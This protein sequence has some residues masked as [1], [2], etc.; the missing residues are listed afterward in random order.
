V[1]ADRLR[2]LKE[3]ILQIIKKII[4][5]I[6]LIPSF[7]LIHFLLSMFMNNLIFGFYEN[8]KNDSNYLEIVKDEYKGKMY[9]RKA[10][11]SSFLGNI[12]FYRFEDS[13]EIGFYEINQYL[14]VDLE[15]I[16]IF[17]SIMNDRKD[18]YL[19]L[20]VGRNMPEF[21]Y[22]IY[23]TFDKYKNINIFS[24]YDISETKLINTKNLFYLCT[25]NYGFSFSSNKKFYDFHLKTLRTDLE[26][27]ELVFF[28]YNGKT[29]FV[30]KYINSEL[31][32]GNTLN[33]KAINYVLLKDIIKK[34]YFKEQD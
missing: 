31:E 26:P 3:K 22:F 24:K 9:L 28:K 4:V 29:I 33:A 12:N 17:N 34:K 6:L 8:K 25:F 30:T 19:E 16:K 1:R 11:K 13:S 10:Y 7:M 5:V 15:K 18:N 23:P 21:W 32:N 14:D 2:F 27:V 20:S